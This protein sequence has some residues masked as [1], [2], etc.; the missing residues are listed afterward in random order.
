MFAWFQAFVFG[1][2]RH[3]M[4]LLLLR[5]HGDARYVRQLKGLRVSW[6][7]RQGLL[8]F[9]LR[10]CLRQRFSRWW[11]EPK[12]SDFLQ[13]KKALIDHFW[14]NEDPQDVIQNGMAAIFRADNKYFSLLEMDYSLA[15]GGSIT[16]PSSVAPHFNQADTGVGPFIYIQ[17]LC[18]LRESKNNRFELPEGK[19][20]VSRSPKDV[21]STKIL[22]RPVTR[23]SNVENKG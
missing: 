12:A 14:H 13:V 17:W 16:R 20:C 6:I 23:L 18:R 1:I 4:F 19:D 21:I 5:K 11:D 9:L 22:V 2:F 8:R 15:K 10:K 7:Y 3:Q